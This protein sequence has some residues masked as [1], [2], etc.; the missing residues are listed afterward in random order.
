M[1]RLDHRMNRSGVAQIEVVVAGVLLFA[2]ASL[3]PSLG[4]HLSR[5][6]KESLQYQI[7][8]QTL[9]NELERLRSLELQT[10]ES[11][12]K[13]PEIP[14]YVLK[15][16]PKATLQAVILRDELGTRVQLS[17]QWERVGNPMPVE[18]VGWLDTNP[19]SSGGE[20]SR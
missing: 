12:L 4:Y 17:M 5:I 9:A 1:I 11:D 3:L 18:L 2:L 20:E 16:L 19:K 7:A 14:S 15:R 8:V 13:N 6:H 10:S